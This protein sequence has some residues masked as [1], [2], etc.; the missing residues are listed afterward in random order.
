MT[1]KRRQQSMF[2]SLSYRERSI[3]V[4]SGKWSI[5]L[6]SLLRSRLRWIISG[7]FG[8]WVFASKVA[9][10]CIF[11]DFFFFESLVFFGSISSATFFTPTSLNQK[12]CNVVLRHN[13]FWKWNWNYRS[14]FPSCQFQYESVT[15]IFWN[16]HQSTRCSLVRPWSS[17]PSRRRAR[18]YRH[19]WCALDCCRSWWRHACRPFWSERSGRT[20]AQWLRAGSESWRRR[21]LGKAWMSFDGS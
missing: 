6:T 17:A 5:G 19:G 1:K 10:S 21:W 12:C 14:S 2:Y 16:C 7:E 15:L 4:M 20:C 11:L 18:N 9:F 3:N 8:N 13:I